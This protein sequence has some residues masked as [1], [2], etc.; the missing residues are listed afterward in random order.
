[1]ADFP[2]RLAGAEKVAAENPGIVVTGIE[3]EL[4]TSYTT[5]TVEALKQ[6]FPKTR[7]VLVMGAD[8]LVELPKWKNWQRL[9]GTVPIAIFARPSYS[10]R[11]LSGKAARLFRSSRISRRQWSALPDMRPP[12]W[13]FLRTK[14]HHQSATRI[15]AGR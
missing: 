13:A 7:F 8:L 9:F 5:D 15:R 10:L 12:A 3:C 2:K 11:A 14:E 6:R 1:M 4:G